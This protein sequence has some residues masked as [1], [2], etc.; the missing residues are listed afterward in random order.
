MFK[1]IIK[2]NPILWGVSVKF[3][4]WLSPFFK[5]PFFAT[6]RY[7]NFFIDRKKYIN[8]GGKAELI[9]AYPCLFDKSVSTP[10]DPQYFYQAVWATSIESVFAPNTLNTFTQPILGCL[11][12][13]TATGILL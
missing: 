7:F 9:D 11:F 5:N 6:K 13:S 3:Y 10:F 2:N 1:A 4:R 12:A 8:L